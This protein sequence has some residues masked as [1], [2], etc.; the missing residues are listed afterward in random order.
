MLAY[1]LDIGDYNALC[2]IYDRL[3]NNVENPALRQELLDLFATPEFINEVLSS[4][5]I[6]GKTKYGDIQSLI[7][8][9][10]IPFLNPILD[11]LADE[12][13]MSLRR[14]YME[15]VREFG[16]SAI[17][18]AVVR[19]RDKRWYVVRNMLVLLR[20]LEATQTVNQVR[21][22]LSHPNSRV[23][24]EVLS[25]LIYFQDP[26]ADRQLLLDLKSDKYEVQSVALQL[27]EASKN[28]QV[29]ARLM[30]LLKTGGDFELK[31]SALHA[32]SAIGN[33]LVLPELG[34][35]LKTTSILHPILMR[36]LK[37]EIIRS[38][39]RYPTLPACQLLVKIP[40]IGDKELTSLAK[41]IFTRLQ[42]RRS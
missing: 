5:S 3:A 38:L 10:G 4:I 9:V 17:E 1:F 14:F 34:Q 24:Q 36:N 16:D 25:T 39:E 7:N 29:L 11:R 26:E 2:R 8:K 42:A 41:E 23:H 30:E 31:K 33:P 12:E 20:T 22:L 13:S 37:L 19:L 6:W 32:L 40:E 15:R 27:V 18:S 21:R 28:P 35:F